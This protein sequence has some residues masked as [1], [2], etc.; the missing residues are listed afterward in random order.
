MIHEECPEC[1]DGV[2]MAFE[3]LVAHYYESGEVDPV[4]NTIG[5][6]WICPRCDNEIE[7]NN[8]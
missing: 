5:E 8:I 6:K 4:V 1:R 7:V 3:V 2:K